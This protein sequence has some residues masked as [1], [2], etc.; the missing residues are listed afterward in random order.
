MTSQERDLI[1]R[2]I[3]ILRGLG[4]KEPSAVA[5]ERCA[6]PVVQFVCR[7]LLRNPGSDM[8]C[9]EL[10]AFFA[11]VAACGEVAVVSKS[12][13]LLRL[14]G[15]MVSTFAVRKSHNVL[16]HGRRQRGYKGIGIQMDAGSPAV[17][18]H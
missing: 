8:T 17:T 13:F 15:I 12:E 14:P 11:E 7:Y 5:P 18:Q 1:C 2:A 4:A 16:R 9:S 6:C 10:W 3:D